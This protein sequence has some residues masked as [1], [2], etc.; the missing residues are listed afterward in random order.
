[1]TATENDKIVPF[2]IQESECSCPN[3][4]LIFE[5]IVIRNNCTIASDLEVSV[6][7]S[8]SV[9]NN[10]NCDS[11]TLSSLIS[12]G[13]PVYCNEGAIAGSIMSNE[14][15]SCWYTS[16]LKIILNFEIIG[17]NVLCLHG[18]LDNLGQDQE[19]GNSKITG[20]YYSHNLTSLI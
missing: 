11:I 13:N 10:I 6:Y 14:N 12:L 5:C 20:L 7:W 4:T 16:Q 17:K 1:M 19:I 18:N 2:V 8:G 9:F 3:Y 15:N